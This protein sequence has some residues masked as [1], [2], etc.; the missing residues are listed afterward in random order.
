MYSF[1]GEAGK[2]GERGVAGAPGALVRTDL[3]NFK[4]ISEIY[5]TLSIS[6]NT[7]SLS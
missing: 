6:L 2:A 4:V 1:Q 5:A 7:W 3:H